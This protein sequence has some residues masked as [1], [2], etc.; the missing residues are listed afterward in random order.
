[1]ISELEQVLA[2]INP[3]NY[4]EDIPKDEETIHKPPT[5]L[6]SGD[7]Y[8]GQWK[9]QLREGKGCIKYADG[10]RYEGWWF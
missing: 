5:Y 10:S 1:M 2:T 9:N 7:I 4:G 6:E 3:F 8:S